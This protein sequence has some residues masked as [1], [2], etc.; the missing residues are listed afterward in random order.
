[1]QTDTIVSRKG[2]ALDAC[3]SGCINKWSRFNTL[4]VLVL[5]CT[6]LLLVFILF[7]EVPEFLLYSK[8]DFLLNVIPTKILSLNSD[9]LLVRN[10]Q[11][12]EIRLT[13]IFGCM[14]FRN[15][16][17]KLVELLRMLSHGFYFRPETG[18]AG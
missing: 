17:I 7:D 11:M 5:T 1:M 3:K 9:A 13:L 10:F 15:L 4:G 6:L 12:T 14:D 8:F 16:K 2:R 18:S